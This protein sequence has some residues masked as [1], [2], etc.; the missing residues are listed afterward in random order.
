MLQDVAANMNRYAAAWD[1]N[2][3]CAAELARLEAAIAGMEAAAVEQSMNKYPALTKT[4]W[5]EEL[6]TAML[7]VNTGLKAFAIATAKPELLPDLNHTANKLGKIS[8]KA[9]LGVARKLADIATTHLA[10]LAAYGITSAELADMEAKASGFSGVESDPVNARRQV[11]DAGLQLEACK[12]QGVEACKM[13]DSLVKVFG[14]SSPEFLFHYFTSRRLRKPASRKRALEVR[15]TG[16]GGAPVYNALVS[17][18]SVKFK[19]RSTERGQVF[20][21]HL[22]AG[23]HKLRIEAEGYPAHEQKLEIV[24]NERHVVEVRLGE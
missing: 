8:G 22:K 23:Q 2:A 9:L 11:K 6:Q 12:K 7:R 21:Q 14:A 20:L 19:R 24:A 15:I 13:L 16:S 1:A 18:P 5:R 4:A 17:L 3:A 10:A